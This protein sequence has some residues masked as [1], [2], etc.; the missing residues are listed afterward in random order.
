MEDVAYT[1]AYFNWRTWRRALTDSIDFWHKWYI[2]FPRWKESGVQIKGRITS[3][4]PKEMTHSI[5]AC[6]SSCEMN[7]TTTFKSRAW[8][9]SR[10]SLLMCFLDL[11]QLNNFVHPKKHFQFRIDQIDRKLGLGSFFGWSL[12]RHGVEESLDSDSGAIWVQGS[13]SVH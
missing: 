9:K 4:Q 11:K 2:D 6:S 10:M 3:Y 5:V 13:H 12:A 7:D 1:W 8:S